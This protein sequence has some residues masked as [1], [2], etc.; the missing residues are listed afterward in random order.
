M[1]YFYLAVNAKALAALSIIVNV[2]K[3]NYG[4]SLLAKYF[5]SFCSELAI[6]LSHLAVFL[7]L[8]SI[9]RDQSRCCF[10]WIH[11]KPSG[12]LCVLV[13]KTFFEQTRIF[14]FCNVTLSVRLG[15]L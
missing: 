7:S 2:H 15:L 4:T 12:V 3:N 11:N 5:A 8:A 6:I 14:L 10:S 1:L 9:A 13:V